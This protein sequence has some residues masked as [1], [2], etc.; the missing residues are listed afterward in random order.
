[1]ATPTLDA[2][3]EGASSNSYLTVVEG[4]TYHDAHLYNTAWTGSTTSQKTVSL[5]WATR[6]LDEWIVWKGAKKTDA[7]ALDWPREGVVNPDGNYTIE[8]N[9]I[10]D[11]VK[12]ATAEFARLLLASDR[13]VTATTDGFSELTIGDITLK[14]DNLTKP[15]NQ[16]VTDSVWSIVQDY[17]DTRNSATGIGAVSLVRV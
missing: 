10:P 13:T 7:Q 15:E 4:N 16:I 14:I 2:T 17:A 1:M 5:I 11:F 8:N 6:L 3:V 12:D 9:L